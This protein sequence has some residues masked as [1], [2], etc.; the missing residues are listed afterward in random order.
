MKKVLSVILATM[1]LL[2][3]LIPTTSAMAASKQAVTIT[4]K[5][6]YSKSTISN[7]KMQ[8]Y[9]QYKN[10]DGETCGKHVMD[11]RP[12][13]DGKKT[14]YLVPGDYRISIWSAPSGYMDDGDV[15]TYFAVKAGQSTS[16]TVPVR[17]KF[18]LKLTVLDSSKNPM[19][20]V[21]VEVHGLAGMIQG[22]TNSKGVV[23]FKNVVYGPNTIYVYKVDKENRYLYQYERITELKSGLG[24]TLEK[25]MTTSALSK[26]KQ[27]SLG[28]NSPWLK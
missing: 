7:L 19:S 23:K 24:T 27:Y 22:T 8:I 10:K 25:T 20:N 16:V 3:I 21:A 6:P 5:D 12:N 4:H 18:T 17:P 28:I 11:Y 2:L 1:M 9:K 15:N 13:S 14:V 26:W